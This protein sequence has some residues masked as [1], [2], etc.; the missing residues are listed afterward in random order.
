MTVD[1]AS[2]HWE[3]HYQPGTIYSHHDKIGDCHYI[4]MVLNNYQ[5]YFLWHSIERW[6]G[7]EWDIRDIALGE[8]GWFDRNRI[9]V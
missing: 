1:E 3:K 4:A 6:N 2:E 7:K 5:I 9:I 8:R